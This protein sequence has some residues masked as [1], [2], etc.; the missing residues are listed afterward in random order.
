MSTPTKLSD[1]LAD[2]KHETLDQSD[3]KTIYE[4]YLANPTVDAVVCDAQRTWSIN[5][6]AAFEIDPT[7]QRRFFEYDLHNTGADAFS[8][9]SS[10]LDIE[11]HTGLREHGGKVSPIT[12]FPQTNPLPTVAAAFTRIVIRFYIPDGPK[13]TFTLNYKAHVYQ[14]DIRKKLATTPFTDA[15]GTIYRSGLINPPAHI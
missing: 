4:H 2:L 3:S 5:N 10:D 11:I 9:F 15:H 1:L 14:Y 13:D 12:H 6:I 8:N 7:T